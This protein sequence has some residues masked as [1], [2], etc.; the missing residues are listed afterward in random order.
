[1]QGCSCLGKTRNCFSVNADVNCY[2]R[3]ELAYLYAGSVFISQALDSNNDQSRSQSPLLKLPGF[4]F[5]FVCVCVFFSLTC[6]RKLAVETWNKATDD[7]VL[8]VAMLVYVIHH[9]DLP[10]LSKHYGSNMSILFCGDHAWE[11]GRFYPL[12]SPLPS[13]PSPG[14]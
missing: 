1:M 8:H 6:K 9:V 4:L 2:I 7:C 3:Q 10:S 5:F 14:S 13:R 11:Q 12:L